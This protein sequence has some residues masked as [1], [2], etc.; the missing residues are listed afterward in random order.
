[1]ASI[2]L[3]TLMCDDVVLKISSD[4]VCLFIVYGAEYPSKTVSPS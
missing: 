1:M 3:Y 2:L 4:T